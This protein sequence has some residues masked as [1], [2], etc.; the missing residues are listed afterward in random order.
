MV[1]LLRR[2][3]NHKVSPD[4]YLLSM[5]GLI[6]LLLVA[7]VERITKDNLLLAQ[8]IF[9]IMEG[10]GMMTDM[11]KNAPNL[12]WHPGTLNFHKRLAEARKIHSENVAFAARLDTM[13][14][15]Y[16]SNFDNDVVL[17][18]RK[19]R[20]HGKLKKSPF[21]KGLR[22][23]LEKSN[24]GAGDTASDEA[25]GRRQHVLLEYT[26]A[27]DNRVLD[28]AVVKE[29][30]RD[31]YVIF[32]IDIE[33]GQRFE[34]QLS[35]E[36]VSNIVD[37]DL[38]VTSVDHVEVWMALLRKV[39]LK[40]VENFTMLASGA[41]AEAN[42]SSAACHNIADVAA[43]ITPGPES[44]E[45]NKGLPRADASLSEQQESFK[46][47]K[48][49]TGVA[50]SSTCHAA[51][52]AGPKKSA[53][54]VS[55]R[56]KILKGKPN[57]ETVVENAADASRPSVAPVKTPNRPAVPSIVGRKSS[58]RAAHVAPRV[59]Y[60]AGLKGAPKGRTADVVL[61][62]AMAKTVVNSVVAAALI[63]AVKH[64]W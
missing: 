1:A 16:H 39:D 40:P 11:M 36:D 44:T 23:A 45:A 12:D 17:K 61:C 31:R 25:K 21:S 35:S 27:Q 64:S 9:A 54:T 60:K 48:D 38:L 52:P 26:K 2:R 37:G 49:S 55:P 42:E 29:P 28:V 22:A 18:L 51:P 41:A 32:G 50:P 24:E 63:S 58:P 15:Y 53:S 5:L 33:D 46:T 8:R 43:D 30:Y 56:G 59:G 6:T 3:Y 19:K 62:K 57:P 13:K 34:L 47:A 4:I 10:P 20:L 7:V 14:P